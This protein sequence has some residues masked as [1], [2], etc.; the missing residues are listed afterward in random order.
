[1][2][3]SNLNIHD[4][5]DPA[6][7]IASSSAFSLNFS[8]KLDVSSGKDHYTHEILSWDSYDEFALFCSQI[9]IIFS[10][11]S[12]ASRFFDHVRMQQGLPMFNIEHDNDCVEQ[13]HS[14]RFL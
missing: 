14:L 4:I 2:T 1:M 10:D 13:F 8:S 7:V 3:P 5:R 12:E 9:G 11:L 6:S